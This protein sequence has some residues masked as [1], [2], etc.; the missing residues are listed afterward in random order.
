MNT[1][2]IL[3]SFLAV[4]IFSTCVTSAV[5]STKANATETAPD[6]LIS[7][8][9]L[10]TKEDKVNKLYNSLTNSKKQEFNILVKGA[11][12]TLDEQ[13]EILKTREKEIN[14]VESKGAKSAVVKKV[15]KWLAAKAGEKSIADITDYLFEWEDNLEQGAENYLVDKCGWNR[16]AAH[17]TVKTASFIFL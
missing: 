6:K 11:N 14:H 8:N 9:K 3:S 7:E 5:T 4:S 17:W 1:K 10:N 15:A 16:T 13:L 2:K 12:L